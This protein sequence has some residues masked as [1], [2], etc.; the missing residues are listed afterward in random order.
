MFCE[1]ERSKLEGEPYLLSSLLPEVRVTA[2][3]LRR[4]LLEG[5]SRR[6]RRPEVQRLPPRRSLS[7]QSHSLV[8][9]PRT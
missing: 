5:D 9:L 3:N 6:W 1:S 4:R 7:I 2:S 8:Q